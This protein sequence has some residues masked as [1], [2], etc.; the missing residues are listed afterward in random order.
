[1]SNLILLVEDEQKTGETLKEALESENIDVDWAQDG[2]DALKVVEKGKY[3]LVVLDLKL[4]GLSGEEVLRGVRK[5][6]PYVEVIIYTNYEEPP[7]MKQLI[8]LGIDGYINKGANANLWDIVEK[9]KAK[10]DPFTDDKINEILES[11]SEDVFSNG[12][13][14]KG[15]P[16]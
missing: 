5:V 8:E 10:L 2:G 12:D 6:D 11:T 13:P 4:P 14:N 7:V 9:V 3:D 15:L 16:K 1:M